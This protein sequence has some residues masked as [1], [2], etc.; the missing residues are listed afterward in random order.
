MRFGSDH[1][2]LVELLCFAAAMSGCAGIGGGRD[3]YGD[4][5]MLAENVRLTRSGTTWT[6]A[7]P[8]ATANVILGTSELTGHFTETSDGSL[9]FSG[10]SS[11]SS[12]RGLTPLTLASSLQ[13]ATA[14]YSGTGY[15]IAGLT[16]SS[17]WG[18]GDTLTVSSGSAVVTVPVPAPETD[19]STLLGTPDGLATTVTFRD[20]QCDAFTVFIQ[21][22]PTSGAMRRILEADIPLAG[23]NRTMPLA[24]QSTIDALQSAGADPTTIYFACMNEVETTEFFPGMRAVPVQAGRMFQVSYADLL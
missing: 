5:I 1:G 6:G 4:A 21:T 19:R 12:E 7:A 8:G 15:T 13:T 24:D 16:G 9:V 22:G 10:V 23:G 18:P 17:V 11:W 3:P 14:S 2:L 20:G